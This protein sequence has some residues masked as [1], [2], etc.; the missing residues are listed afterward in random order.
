M[1]ATYEQLSSPRVNPTQDAALRAVARDEGRGRLEVSIAERCG[2]ALIE[3]FER[4][5][6][7]Y[8][9]STR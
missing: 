2:E 3:A 6:A 9:A 8:Y 5:A 7:A 4:M 1:A